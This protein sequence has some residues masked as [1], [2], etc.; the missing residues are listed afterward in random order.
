MQVSAGVMSDRPHL[1]PA[2]ALGLALG[3]AGALPT[4]NWIL[5]PLVFG[6]V[7][8]A[9]SLADWTR[10]RAMIREQ[11]SASPTLCWSDGAPPLEGTAAE[12]DRSLQTL[13]YERA[14]TL[15]HSGTATAVYVHHQL[16]IYA[17]ME[18]GP[19][20]SVPLL[21]LDTFVEGGGR[22]TT[23]SSRFLARVFAMAQGEAP[24][25]AQLRVNGTPVALD[26]QHVGTVRAWTAGKRRA[27]PATREALLGYLEQDDP[28]LRDRLRELGWLPF[29]VYLRWQAGDPPGVLTF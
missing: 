1:V 8:G 22:L 26:G 23:C 20:G 24:R 9:A 10:L 5:V 4:G 7:A 12:Y 15:D 16:P 29:P 11:F 17:R 28:R 14:G 3:T 18:L 21:Q 25:L 13:G 2:A 27:L 6:L 19:G